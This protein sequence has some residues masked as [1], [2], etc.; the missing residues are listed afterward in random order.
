[1]VIYNHQDV[2]AICRLKKSW[3]YKYSILSG[4]G[5]FNV[6][7]KKKSKQRPNRHRER[8]WA[9]RQMDELPD[10]LFRRMFRLDRA[11]FDAHVILLKDHM[12]PRNEQKAINSSG[13]AI[14][15]K[16]RLAVSLRWLAGGSYLDICFAFAISYTSF[17][18][19][20]GNKIFISFCII[21][22]ISSQITY[23]LIIVYIIIIINATFN[24]INIS[25]IIKKNLRMFVGN[26]SSPS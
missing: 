19:K 15:F 10:E 3:A 18:E 2:A 5:V 17:Y 23:F 21:I 22:D 25:V 20:D 13:S 26:S 12:R 6:P 14:S 7:H 24:D 4:M 8:G 11:T 1:M 16:T 9:L